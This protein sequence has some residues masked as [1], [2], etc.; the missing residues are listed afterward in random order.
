ME[1]NNYLTQVGEWLLSSGIR[2]FVILILMLI[3][4]K[5]SSILS[6]RLMALFK[7]GKDDTELE[8]RINT[9]SST[10]RYVFVIAIFITAAIMILNELGIEVGPILAAAGVVG[11]AIGFGAQSLVQ[12]IISGFFILLEDQVRVG[13]VVEIAGKAGLV[14]RVN[15]RMVVLRDLE[16]RVHYVRNGEIKIVSNFT[17]EF[18]CYVFDIGVAYREDVDHVIS[19]LKELD[20]EFRQ[21]TDFKVKILQPLEIFGVDQ[22]ADSAV[23]IKARYQTRAREQWNVAREFNR[24]LKIRFDEEGIEIPFPHRTL[25]IG[26][27]KDGSSPP[28]NI[29]NETNHSNGAANRT[30]AERTSA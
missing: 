10:L 17:K 5:M 7:R 2:I 20:E 30:S 23:V 26:V 9:L 1:I 21:D 11:L 18:S 22:F 12:D 4:T 6:T 29:S 27:D 16:G 3:G 28:L 24:R 25:Y 15:L 13:D 19:V 8:K 14:E